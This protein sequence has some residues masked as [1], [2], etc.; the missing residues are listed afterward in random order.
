MKIIQTGHI[1]TLDFPPDNPIE[2]YGDPE[3]INQLRDI[4]PL[5][6]TATG[7]YLHKQ[8]GNYWQTLTGLTPTYINGRKVSKERID[9]IPEMQP[10]YTPPDWLR[11]YQKEAVHLC[12]KH[13]RGTIEVPTSGG[14]TNIIGALCEALMPLTNV[15]ITVPTQNLMYQMQEEVEGYFANQGMS[16]DVG[17]IGDGN[18]KPRGL[19]IGIP[20]S[21]VS[22]EAD[23]DLI[24]Y[25]DKV[26]VWLADE[27]HT[28]AN[29]R[30]CKLSQ[31][32]KRAR[33]RLGF[34]A[35]TDPG[36]NQRPLLD[37]LHGPVIYKVKPQ[38]LMGEGYILTPKIKIH[39]APYQKA[40]A[41]LF[42]RGRGAFYGKT[43]QEAVNGPYSNAIY[44]RLYDA[45]IVSNEDR[46]RL[47]A[48]LIEEH[49]TSCESPLL[50]IV[51]K[52]DAK[53][54][55]SQLL[56][57]IL[58]DVYGYTLP[59][60][61]GSLGKNKVGSLI[62]ALREREIPGAIAG[63]RVLSVGTN[64]HSLGGL[65]Y[66]CGGKCEVDVIQRIGRVLRLQEGKP[67]PIVHDFMD[68]FRWFNSQSNK[69]MNLY[70]ETYGE[71]NIEYC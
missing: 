43:F 25:L 65:I 42:K 14:K 45:L 62:N 15:L 51:N 29:Y 50:V 32:L 38:E 55:H 17:L 68:E 31:M 46:N 20:N 30:G 64:I 19:T 7:A 37:G 53:V 21:F 18:F 34:S 36:S 2:I 58:G 24:D 28:L 57:N 66:A 41:A 52:V 48:R 8:E 49:I 22:K 1:S 5:T 39:A 12:L 56:N 16:V 6:P 47:I 40:M 13:I 61:K 44:N 9:L 59:V 11:Y 69:R 26:G 60:I 63:P 27:C 67:N 33:Y 3:F 35:T 71:Q 23:R 4:V 10:Q 70:K 54:S